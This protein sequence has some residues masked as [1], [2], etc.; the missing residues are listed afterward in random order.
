MPSLDAVLARLD[1]NREAALDRLFRL[2]EIPS[3]SA[4]PAYKAE[5]RR[6][7]EW[8]TAELRGLGFEA[9]VRDTQGHP[10]VLGHAKAKRRD[11]PH[12]LFY[13]HYD[14]QPVDPLELWNTKPFEPRLAD[15]P[16]GKQI[17]ARGACDDKGQLMTF[18]EAVRAFR[19]AGDL[20]CDISILF[21]GEEE[22]GSLSLPKFMADNAAELKADL[23]LVCDT[24]MWDAQT[25]A[26]TAMLRGILL[27]EVIVRAANRDLHS[28]MYGGAAINP[29]RV[30]ANI[31]AD[32][33][34][35]D[36]RIAVPG[37]YDGVDELPADIAEQWRALDF[38]EKA[39][40]G[41]VGLS[42]PAGEKGRS[43]LE[44]IW[45]RPTCDVNGIVGG[46]TLA[47][48]KTV[49]P[50]QASAKISFRLVGRQDAAKIQTSFRDFVRARLPA[51]CEVEFLAHG[52]SGAIALPFA[53]ETLNRARRA[54]A[55]EWGREPVM[56]ASGGSIPIVGDFKSKLG[57][58]A[59]LVGFGLDDDKV[60][61]PNE[62]YELSSFQRGARSWARILQALS[63]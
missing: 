51:D 47:G 21:E 40:L 57:M 42:V 44:M 16:N 6:A 58:D 61:S 30:L 62:K 17:V 33:H 12:V 24:G 27:E 19:E 53:S 45:S 4:D 2:L 29:I 31:I 25:P 32:L 23:M 54:L 38:D 48:S 37:F 39:F 50:A 20:P 55:Q 34:E 22:S 5:C 11:V 63:N 41:E 18:V 52:G 9:S 59:L 60:H 8:L 13:G 56:A 15:G 35:P 3:I 43:V 49:L 1:A 36:G 26:I 28:G 10:M 14:V 7:A 46:Y